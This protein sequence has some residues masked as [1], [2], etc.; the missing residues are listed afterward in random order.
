MRPTR[1]NRPSGASR[2]QALYWIDIQ[3]PALHR[4]DPATGRGPSLA[5]AGRDRLFRTRGR[6]ARAR[7]WAFVV[8]FMSCTLDTERCVKLAPAPFDPALFRFNEGGCDR[9]GRFWLGTMF[10]PKDS[11][12]RKRTNRKGEWHSYTEARGPD[13]RI[14]ILPSFPN[15]LAW[16]RRYRTMYISHSNDGHHLRLRFRR[17]PRAVWAGG[18]SSRPFPRSSASPTAAPSMS[19]GATGAPFMAGGGCG[20]FAPTAASIRMC[21]CR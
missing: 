6:L 5:A 3:Q 10:D 11:T 8:A 19:K 14:A 2:E 15:G 21:I 1:A 18:A 16:D 20:A 17:R 4:F 7:S 12:A 9:T 13:T